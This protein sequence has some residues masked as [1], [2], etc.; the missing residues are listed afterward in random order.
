MSEFIIS[1]LFN[2]LWLWI[3]FKILEVVVRFI[4]KKMIYEM[5]YGK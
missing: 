2:V 1:V 3:I 5:R 4:V